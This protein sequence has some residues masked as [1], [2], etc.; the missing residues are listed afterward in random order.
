MS[1]D[2]LIE[3][4]YPW[5]GYI[6]RENIEAVAKRIERELT[7]KFFTIATVIYNYPEPEPKIELH[8]KLEKVYFY[9][10]NAEGE[11]DFSGMGIS[12]S[13]AVRTIS[14]SAHSDN[15]LSCSGQPLVFFDINRITIKQ[16]RSGFDNN[17][18][19]WVF[20]IERKER[21]R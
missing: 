13:D 1:R 19:I 3:E 18:I 15:I 5:S 20:A 2:D 9:H 8:Q 4:S 10:G 21:D 14:T 16:W 11:G 7:N 6:T 12:H 17:L